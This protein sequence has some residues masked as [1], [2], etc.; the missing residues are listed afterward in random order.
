LIRHT[1]SSFASITIL[2]QQITRITDT[3]S[4]DRRYDPRDGIAGRNAISKNAFL[5]KPITAVKNILTNVKAAFATY[6]TAQKTKQNIEQLFRL[7]WRFS[8]SSLIKNAV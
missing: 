3:Q 4:I 2:A 1:Y 8:D 5:L 7:P 6:M